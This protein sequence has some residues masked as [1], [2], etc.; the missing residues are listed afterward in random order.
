MYLVYLVLCN[1]YKGRNFVIYY[2]VDEYLE[3]NVK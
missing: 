3:Y 1:N 2:N